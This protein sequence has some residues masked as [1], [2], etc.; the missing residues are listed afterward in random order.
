M[1]LEL[2][3]LL[4]LVTLLVL[5]I[6]VSGIIVLL[7]GLGVV[8]ALVGC[9]ILLPCQKLLLVLEIQKELLRLARIGC[10][11]S[12]V[13]YVLSCCTWQ[14][15]EV[16]PVVE[17]GEVE[18]LVGWLL[19]VVVLVDLLGSQ[20]LQLELLPGVHL[21]LHARERLDLLHGLRETPVLET[22]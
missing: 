9:V 18:R 22:L 5:K 15:H 6:F 16:L 21:T 7:V 13:G 11:R 1:R 19:P 17:D 14:V 2:A 10:H 4:L 12:H 20:L 3:S 8:A